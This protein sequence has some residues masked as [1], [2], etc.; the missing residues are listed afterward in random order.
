MSESKSKSPPATY[1]T[2][3][4]SK[5]LNYVKKADLIAFLSP[6]KYTEVEN[7]LKHD[8]AKENI[9]L[10]DVKRFLANA[11][12]FMQSL[13]S[14]P[15]GQQ[16]WDKYQQALTRL[17]DPQ[18]RQKMSVV[19]NTMRQPRKRMLGC[20]ATRIQP[21]DYTHCL[22]NYNDDRYDRI[23]IIPTGLRRRVIDNT[24]DP[25]LKSLLVSKSTTFTDLP[26]GLRTYMKRN[27]TEFKN[28][29]NERRHELALIKAVMKNLAPHEKDALKRHYEEQKSLSFEDFQDVITKSR[30][31]RVAVAVAPV[32]LSQEGVT[33]PIALAIPLEAT[34]WMIITM[35][36]SRY[37]PKIPALLTS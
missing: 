7:R 9:T 32:L 23:A 27:P 3:A 37:P 1:E 18:N 2:I 19:R 22:D 13:K 30:S 14:N 34:N 16:A 29:Y 17:S 10:K 36:P 35:T 6:A 8:L 24:E 25:Q 26:T 11:P 28:Y 21:E 31:V 20:L 33:N 4:P 5:L 12:E 15:L